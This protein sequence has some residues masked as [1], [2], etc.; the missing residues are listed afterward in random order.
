MKKYLFVEPSFPI[1]PKSKNHS[2]FLPIGL[3][4]LASYHRK[5]GHK[6][7]L[8]RGNQ[9]AG[10]Y[11][12]KIFITSLFTYWSSYV[13]DAVTYYRKK[14]PKAIIEVGGIYAT[15]MPDHCREFTGCNKVF[16][17]Q[18]SG[19]EKCFPA[20]DLVN[21]KY[22]IVHGMRGC[23]RKCP[24][25]GIWKLETKSFK[26]V[27]DIKK[28]ICS[29]RII[30]YDNN[31][32]VN[33]YIEEILHMLSEVTFKGRPVTCECQSGFDG[34]ILEERPSLA[35][36]IKKARF[37]NI[38]VAWDFTYEQFPKIENWINLLENAGYKRR[39]TFVFMVY[40][41]SFD[42]QELEK[43]RNKCFEW[44]VQIA[45]CR[46]RPLDQTF[47]NYNSRLIEQTSADYYIHSNW[48]DLEIRKFRKDVRKH[49]ICL[50]Y[51]I[52]WDV[53]EAK[54]ERTNA[55]KKFFCT[56]PDTCPNI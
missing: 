27:D 26:T 14:Y 35:A 49:N 32:L 4:K 50:R 38:R 44:G 52:P 53:Y 39:D 45:D 42:Y 12:D 41:W 6:I 48:S 29:N 40:N 47:D 30:F 46:F 16:I 36:M 28:E 54:A 51:K 21:V 25:C 17:G 11:P 19:A 2:N 55:K 13:K 18:H 8:N 9:L 3:L 56:V 31:I 10:F 37:R 33:P 7:K 34:R 1:P 5:K 23:S 22:Q 20:Y 15:L 43:K 24:F